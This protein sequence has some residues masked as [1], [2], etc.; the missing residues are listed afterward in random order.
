MFLCLK[1]ESLWAEIFLE[2]VGFF[3]WSIGSSVIFP[4]MY[5]ASIKIEP[6]VSQK[7]DI[8]ALSSSSWRS[9][10]GLDDVL[11]LKI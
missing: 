8:L 6:L 10:W 7:G 11:S 5:Y 4:L 1:I 9:L 2:I 3:K